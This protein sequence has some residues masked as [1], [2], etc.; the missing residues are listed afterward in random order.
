[1]EIFKN[2]WA[3]NQECEDAFRLYRERLSTLP[4][5]TEIRTLMSLS[6]VK[7]FAGFHLPA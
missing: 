1:M 5:V 6:T 4:H 7:P 2:L 3:A